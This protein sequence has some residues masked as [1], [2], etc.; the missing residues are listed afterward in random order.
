MPIS[1]FFQ[2]RRCCRHSRGPVCC[3]AVVA[4]HQIGHGR[5]AK[6]EAIDGSPA[7]CERLCAMGLY[8]GGLVK[9]VQA[10]S[11]CAVEV[12]GTKLMLRGEP[13]EAIRVVQVEA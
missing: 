9:V 1:R 10:G 11:P 2:R 7:L 4:L 12:C 13:L 8:V 3:P 6:I 5:C